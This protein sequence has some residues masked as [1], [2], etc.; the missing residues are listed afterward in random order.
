MLIIT[1]KLIGFKFASGDS[2]LDSHIDLMLSSGSLQEDMCGDSLSLDQ[3]RKACLL[4]FYEFH[5]FPGQQAWM[6]VGKLTRLA[7]WI[8]LDRLDRFESLPSHNLG[9]GATSQDDCEDWRLVW[10]FVYRLDTYANLSSGTPY[11]IDDRLVRTALICDQESDC[12]PE[13]RRSHQKPRLYLPPHP[14]GLWELVPAITSASH[15]TSLFNLHIITATATRQAGR[16]LQSHMIGAPDETVASLADL[17]RRLS[18]LR[19]SLPK[20]YLNP[21]RNAFSNETHSGHHARLITVLHLLMARLLVSIMSCSRLDEG[22][23]WLLSW[24]QVLETCQDIASISEQWN[25]A[26]SLSVDPAVS[27]IIFTALIFVDLHKKFAGV[28]DSALHSN[29]EHCEMVLLLLLEQFANT[30]T[31]PRLLIREY[32]LSLLPKRVLSC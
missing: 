4:A 1:A 21:M 29:L 10:W 13:S 3:F 9:W 5:Q 12:L 2:D 16:A 24:Q 28:T 25:S 18:A 19:L 20:N 31:L 11:L 17:E 27:F 23:E 7:Y 15:Q 30:W 8:G 22:D 6:R 14:D 32:M 26:F